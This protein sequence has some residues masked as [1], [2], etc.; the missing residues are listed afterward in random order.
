MKVFRKTGSFETELMRKKRDKEVDV[1]HGALRDLQIVDLSQTQQMRLLSLDP[2]GLN[3][4]MQRN[5]SRPYEEIC[6]VISENS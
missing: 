5:L 2:S 1:S 6:N 4:T 3:V